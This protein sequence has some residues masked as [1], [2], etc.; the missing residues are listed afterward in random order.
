M[1]KIDKNKTVF[2]VLLSLLVL[3]SACKYDVIPTPPGP[4]V[5]KALD[6]LDAVYVS[7]SPNSLSSA[8]WATANYHPVTCVNL[9]TGNL[10]GDGLLNM[11]GTF[12]GVSDFYGGKSPDLIMKAAYDSINLYILLEWNDST[13]NIANS[14]WYVNGNP[15]PLKADTIS[16]WTSQKNNDKV[17]LAWEIQPATGTGGT[18]STSG[19]AATCHS[20]GQMGLTSGSVDIWNWNLALSEPMGYANDMVITPSSG[21][22][23]DAGNPTFA[24]NSNNSSN[25]SGPAFSWNGVLQ[26]IVRGNG[27]TSILDP[28]FFL[29][30]KT[31]L[32]GD[33][34]GGDTSYHNAVYG[35]WNCHGA[36]GEGNGPLDAGVPFLNNA[37]IGRYSFQSFAAF[38]SAS[39]TAP[40]DGAPY[41][42]QMTPAQQL[43]VYTYILGIAGVPGYYLQEPTGSNADIVS[44]SNV[45]LVNV[46][47]FKN[48]Q[49]KVLL[50]R[51]LNTGNSDDA[52]FN[53][54]QKPVVTFGVALMDNDGINH[55]GSFKE[56][57]QFLKK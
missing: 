7:T 32:S 13:L 16:E 4:V 12:T 38:S 48:T 54:V 55:V 34:Y 1:K 45:N 11:T 29:Y 30:N 44:T 40:H 14:N 26:S 50:V 25:R 3:I 10:Y 57:L 49:Y 51:K 9:S 39:T 35:C 20:G 37:N 27:K 33:V 17:S 56:T 41:W 2:G 18:F 47:S 42:A 23:Y 53:P 36:V 6:T 5:P 15:D 52:V 28:S 19:C 22:T 24:R 46:S 31:P 43:D 8:Y 21:L